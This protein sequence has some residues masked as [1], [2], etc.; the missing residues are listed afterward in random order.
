MIW[1]SKTIFGNVN[2]VGEMEEDDGRL[3]FTI[4]MGYEDNFVTMKSWSRKI[5]GTVDYDNISDARFD[6]LVAKYQTMGK[7]RTINRIYTKLGKMRDM[8]NG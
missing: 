4:K 2:I 1:A 6:R 8:R 7:D 3:N 5:F